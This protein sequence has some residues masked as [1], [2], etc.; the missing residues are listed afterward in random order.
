MNS[1]WTYIKDTNGKKINLK[2]TF[3]HHCFT[4]SSSKDTPSDLLFTKN[5]DTREICFDRYD[6]SFKLRRLVKGLE[7][8]T[9]FHTEANSF[10]FM[11]DTDSNG[12]TVKYTIFFYASARSSKFV[13]INITS[14]HN[15]PNMIEWAS[16]I[17]FTQLVEDKYNK[18][19]LGKG[20][21]IRI[22]RIR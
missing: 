4:K 19:T 5:N 9:V 7:N 16:P 18:R 10:F 6:F 20:K 21:K 11:S 1:F 17:R 2:V 15:K 14:A 13:E 3:S 22:K 8:Y 12:Q